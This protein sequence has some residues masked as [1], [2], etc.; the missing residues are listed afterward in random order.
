[1][2]HPRHEANHSPQKPQENKPRRKQQ[3]TFDRSPHSRAACPQA[4]AE[5]LHARFPEISFGK[6]YST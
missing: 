5:R 6:C 2:I 1:T 3:L 4:A